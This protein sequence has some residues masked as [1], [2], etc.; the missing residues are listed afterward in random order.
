MWSLFIK[1]SE[2][3][4]EECH[5][6]SHNV[7]LNKHLQKTQRVPFSKNIFVII[8][9]LMLMSFQGIH[10]EAYLNPQVFPF[11]LW[12]MFSDSNLC[13]FTF[14]VDALTH[15]VSDFIPFI[16]YSE[17]PAID[18]FKCLLAEN[19]F[20]RVR[21]RTGFPPILLVQN[22]YNFTKVVACLYQ[23]QMLTTSSLLQVKEPKVYI[24]G[25]VRNK[26]VMHRNWPGC[27]WLWW[28]KRSVCWNFCED[29]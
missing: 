17:H 28:G 14:C 22:R 23:N 9:L 15:G 5:S 19:G 20:S 27:S 13:C 4:F 10:G 1:I 3:F 26:D 25:N 7:G 12:W 18:G 16:Y 11:L 21:L 29:E 2:L 24:H 6:F 8:I